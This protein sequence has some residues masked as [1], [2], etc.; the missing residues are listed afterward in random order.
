MEF[1]GGKGPGASPGACKHQ[2]RQKKRSKGLAII[3]CPHNRLPIRP[4]EVSFFR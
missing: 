4:A 2:S 3:S 1:L